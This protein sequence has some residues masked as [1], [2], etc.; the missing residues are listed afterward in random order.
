MKKPKGKKK[1]KRS[2]NL[3]LESPCIYDGIYKEDEGD[4]CKSLVL[5]IIGFVLFSCGAIYC[6]VAIA[7]DT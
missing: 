2:R 7:W 4:S 5:W 1:P 3:N 6:L